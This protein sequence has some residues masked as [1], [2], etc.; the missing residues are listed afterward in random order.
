MNLRHYYPLRARHSSE[1][2]KC[3]KSKFYSFQKYTLLTNGSFLFISIIP[4]T[5]TNLYFV[6][7]TTSC[8]V[9]FFPSIFLLSVIVLLSGNKYLLYSESHCQFIVKTGKMLYIDLDHFISNGTTTIEMELYDSFYVYSR[10]LYDLQ[11][12]LASISMKF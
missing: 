9:V 6:L 11:T 1:D 4:P 12:K 10:C 5:R 7:Y 8:F 2:H 3:P